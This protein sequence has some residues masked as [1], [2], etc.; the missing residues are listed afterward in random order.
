MLAE[1]MLKVDEL[2]QE[3][4]LAFIAGPCSV[5]GKKML[6]ETASFLSGLG[7]KMLR[8]GLFKP[9]TSPD[10]F[11]GLREKGLS[12]MREVS[13][14]YG[15]IMITEVMDAEN[16]SM[17]GQYTD[18]FQVGSRNSQN[19]PLLTALGKQKKP[20]LLKRG[21]GNTTEEFYQSSRYISSQGNDQIIL[22]E[23]GIRTFED[24]T[25]FTLDISS[26]PVMRKRV[27]Y[28]IVIDPSHPAGKREYVEPLSLA[29][30]A[31]GANGLMIEVHPDPDNALSDGMQQV[32]F[33]QFEQI[34]KKAL[35]IRNAMNSGF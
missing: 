29:A 16:I 1:R 26:I 23:R 14:D 33:E 6:E 18:V 20:V 10:S 8:G 25:R 31:A 27:G 7:V 17:V 15:M 35:V 34:Y 22:V 30:V 24:S 3:G 19:F 21:F 9:R 4:K 12:I 2:F 13:D 11:Q 5:E 28:P 32:N